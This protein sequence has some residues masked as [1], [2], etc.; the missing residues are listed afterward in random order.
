MEAQYMNLN[1]LKSQPLIICGSDYWQS[2]NPFFFFLRISLEELSLV[3]FS[4]VT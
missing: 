3:V 1:L 2:F 4:S